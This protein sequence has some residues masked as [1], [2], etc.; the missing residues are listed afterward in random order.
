MLANKFRN[1]SAVY[2]LHGERKSE[3]FN[4]RVNRVGGRGGW[5]I[6]GRIRFIEVSIGVY[7]LEGLEVM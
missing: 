7:W 3:R 6:F 1:V 5:R 2:Q 4:I